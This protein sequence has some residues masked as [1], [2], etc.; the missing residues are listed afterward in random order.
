M[1]VEEKKLWRAMVTYV[2]KGHDVQK[3]KFI[4]LVNIFTDMW[5]MEFLKL[6]ANPH[7]G[8]FV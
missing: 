4:Y 6:Y 5:L 1:H 3:K 8:Y 2:L 7:F